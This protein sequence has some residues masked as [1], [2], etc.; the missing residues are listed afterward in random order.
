MMLMTAPVLRIDTSTGYKPLTWIMRVQIALD[1]AKG[2]EY[3][4]LNTK[5]SFIHRDVK[6]SNIL[7]DSGFH[8]KVNLLTSLKVYFS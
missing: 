3:I 6:S 8:A 7:L 2:L 1:A 5:P 4:H